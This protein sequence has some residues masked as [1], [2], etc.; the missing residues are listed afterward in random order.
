MVMM[1][2]VIVVMAMPVDGACLGL[3]TG[4]INIST[5]N[6]LTSYFVKHS[7]SGTHRTAPDAALPANCVSSTI[8]YVPVVRVT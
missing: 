7:A 3:P 5:H 2:V 6:N 4:K 1:M 8:T